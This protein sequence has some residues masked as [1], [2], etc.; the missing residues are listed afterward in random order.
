MIS[1]GLA[2]D[3]ADLLQ[4]LMVI[5]NVPVILILGNTAVKALE[6]YKRKRRAGGNAHFKA[7]DIGLSDTDCWK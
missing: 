2:W 1:A 6:D 5:I 4:A 7:S 3:T